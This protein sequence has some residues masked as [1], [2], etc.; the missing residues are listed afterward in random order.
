MLTVHF[1]FVVVQE[2][3]WKDVVGD[4]SGNELA[5]HLGKTLVQQDRI[6]RLNLIKNVLLYFISSNNNLQPCIV[7]ELSKHEK[8]LLVTSLGWIVPLKE[9][10]KI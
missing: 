5:Q 1:A 4:G 10:G 2:R 3:H 8:R 6:R 7:T 9:F